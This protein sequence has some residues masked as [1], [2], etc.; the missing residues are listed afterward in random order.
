MTDKDGN[1]YK[2]IKIGKQKWMAENLNVS[3]YRNGD[4]IPQVQDKDEWAKLTTGAWCYYENDVENG[5]IYGKLYN[6]YAVNEPRG[7][8][9]EGWHISNDDEWGILIDRLGGDD[10]AA[11]RR[12][13]RTDS[14]QFPP[15]A[16]QRPPRGMRITLLQLPR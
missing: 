7:L 16:L 10:G 12:R 14:P 11:I 15:R 9:P 8:A 5:K 6:W 13:R 1:T 3:S 2:T 4:P